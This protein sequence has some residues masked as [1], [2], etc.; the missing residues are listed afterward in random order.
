[1]D[2]LSDILSLLKPQSFL[3]AGFDAGGAWAVRFSDQAGQIKC[4]VVISGG[5]M[6]SVEGV[7]QAVRLAAG[8]CF[9]LPT[10]RSFTLGS[11]TAIT[12]LEANEVFAQPRQK[13]IIVH[14]GASRWTD[15]IRPSC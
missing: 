9:V 14:N 7:E 15:G 13:G 5:C 1:M 12:P 6:L 3:T 2:P 11:D 4:Y 8:D 10:G